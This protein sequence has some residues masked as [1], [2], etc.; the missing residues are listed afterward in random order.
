MEPPETTTA[1]GIALTAVEESPL[2]AAFIARSRTG[3]EVPLVKPVMVSGEVV[4]TG[5]R[6]VQFAPLLV[7]YS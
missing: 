3:Y 6:V 5:E 1:V 7:E 2:P 4:E